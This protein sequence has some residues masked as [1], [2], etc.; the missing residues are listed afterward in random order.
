MACIKGAVKKLK[1][2]KNDPLFV[3]SSECLKNAPDDLFHH[4]AKIIRSFIYHGHVSSFLLIS[5]MIPLIKDKFGDRTSSKNYRSIAIGS[6]ICKLIDII[7]IDLY[8]DVFQTDELQ[9]GFQSES[10]TSMCTW[11]AI[12]TISYYN[13]NKT[14]VYG[15]FM[16]LSKAFDK[17]QHSKLFIKLLHKGLPAII[18]RLILSMYRNQEV[19]VSW[20][21]NKSSRFKTY[22]GVKQGAILSPLLFNLYIDKIFST[23]RRKKVGC[24]LGGKYTGIVGYADDLLL[25][26]PSANGLQTMI[27]TCENYANEHGLTFSTDIIPSKSKT[28]CIKFEVDAKN[29][30]DIQLG[31]N[32]LP[33]VSNADHLGVHININING[34]SEDIQRKRASYIQ[35]NN[36]II[37]ETPKS[38]PNL[39]CQINS[40]FNTSFYGAQIWD[41]F[42]KSSES[43]YNTWNISIRKM[44]DLPYQTHRY[45]IEPL[46]ERSHIKY[47]LLKRVITFANTLRNNKKDTVKSV[48]L[49]M[50]KDTNSTIGKNLRKIMK[51]CG[52]RYV[53]EIRGT[54]ID[55]LTYHIVTKENK[56]TLNLVKELIDMKTGILTVN[57]FSKEEI[58]EMLHFTCTI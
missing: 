20:N 47:S 24:W 49:M 32:K 48:F 2:S 26:C 57:E 53:H 5:S 7:I 55:K 6:L 52:K 25:L 31:N 9:F 4:L 27:K 11:L 54:D 51:L 17:V 38:H 42:D 39:R 23:L 35:R 58:N 13:R 21:G 14:N 12:E 22:N 56:W 3:L 18:C 50:E 43:L 8:G 16:D 28:K 46:S 1:P 19:Y 45:Y 41:L 44:F 36:E 15:C 30:P 29:V 34:L 10:S 33:W 37:Q 40:L